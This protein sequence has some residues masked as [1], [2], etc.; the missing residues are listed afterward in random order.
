MRHGLMLF[1]SWIMFVVFKEYVLKVDIYA[2]DPRVKTLVLNGGW[3]CCC[4]ARKIC[5]KKF[6]DMR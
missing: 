3:G 5:A 1:L 2:D 6:V 4:Y